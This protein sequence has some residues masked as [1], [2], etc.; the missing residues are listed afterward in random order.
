MK[1]IPLIYIFVCIISP[2]TYGVFPDFKLF[3]NEFDSSWFTRDIT[4]TIGL[5]LSPCIV[6]IK[7]EIQR[8]KTSILFSIEGSMQL[9]NLLASDNSFSLMTTVIQ[10]IFLFAAVLYIYDK[11]SRYKTS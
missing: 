3:G 9:F 7:N 4:Y 10:C 11:Y 8:R 1:V 6:F 2:M 5:I